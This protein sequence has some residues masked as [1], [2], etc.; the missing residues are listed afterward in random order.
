MYSKRMYKIYESLA[1]I[2]KNLIY[3]QDIYQ[4]VHSLHTLQLH[5]STLQFTDRYT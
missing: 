2:T 1:I 3:L 4:G 5:H